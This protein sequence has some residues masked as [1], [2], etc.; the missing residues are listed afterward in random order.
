MRKPARTTAS[1]GDL[2]VAAFDTAARL[3]SDPREVSR[4]ATRIV[5]QMVRRGGRVGAGGA[6]V[7]A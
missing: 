1:L 3:S 6:A 2:V 7:P 4:L 5:Q